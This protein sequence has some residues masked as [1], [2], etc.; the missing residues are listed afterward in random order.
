[1]A[2]VV[3]G[4]GQAVGGDDGVGLHIAQR[5]SSEGVEARQCTD[6]SALL[7][8][9]EA[10]RS[11]IL[12]DGVVCR[13]AP[14]TVLVLQPAELGQRATALSSHGLGVAE[15]LALAETLYGGAVQRVRIVGI[16]IEPPARA[17][18]GLSPAVARALTPAC[19]VVRALLAEERT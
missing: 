13:Q 16:V 1:V 2:S 9:L 6:A 17:A 12:V 5:L 19:D 8:W 3:I 14:G 11:V 15:V 4:L 18:E 10:G 7:P